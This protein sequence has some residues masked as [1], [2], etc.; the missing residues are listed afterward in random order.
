MH[1]AVG[2]LYFYDI[3]DATVCVVICFDVG[4]HNE[5]AIGASAAIMVGLYHA[6][7]ERLKRKI[8]TRIAW[9]LV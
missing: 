8:V 9:Q 7:Y 3:I 6:W 1:G 4:E 2:F 5:G